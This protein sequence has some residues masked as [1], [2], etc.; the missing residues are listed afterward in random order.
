MRNK[1][2]PGFYKKSPMKQN[3]SISDSTNRGNTTSNV[4]ILSKEEIKKSNTDGHGNK[5]KKYVP[6]VDGPKVIGG[7]VPFGG[8]KIIGGLRG[9]YNLGKKLFN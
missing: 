1:P 4:R 2:L 9:V 8:G 5:L 7:A 3:E 6:G